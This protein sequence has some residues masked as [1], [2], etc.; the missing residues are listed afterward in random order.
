MQW[1]HGGP[2]HHHNCVQKLKFLINS[3]F[4]FL[5]Y[6]LHYESITIHLRETWKIQNQVTYSFTVKVKVKVAQS[7][8]TLWDPQWLYSPWNSL[9][10][11]NGVGTPLQHSCLKNPMDGGDWWAAVHT[12]AKSRTRLS[13]FPFTFHFHALEKEMATHSSVL[14]WRVPWTGEPGGLYGVAQS[15]TWLKRLSSSSSLSLL[16]GIF[17]NRR[18]NLGLLH[19]RWILYQ[20][21]HRG[22]PRIL[23]WV[24]YSVSSGSS[25][26]RNRTGVSCISGGFFTS[27]A[28]RETPLYITI[29]F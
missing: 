17:P 25:Q 23:D 29:I 28:I 7:C 9:G 26:F 13:D 14:A 8:P 5:F 20:L 1:L 19:C 24:A 21:S 15:R 16:Q 10:Q 11:N 18:S 3:F 6:F 22:S 2:S 4:L 27:W 12:V